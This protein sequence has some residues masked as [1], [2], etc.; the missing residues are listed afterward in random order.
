[1]SLAKTHE[2]YAHSWWTPDPWWHWVGRTFRLDEDL[3][4]H[5]RDYIFDPCPGDWDGGESG[6]EIPWEGPCYVNHP[7][8]RGGS[9]QLWWVKYQAEQERHNGMM[10]FVWCAFSVEQLRHLRPSPFH[11]C[12]WL[13]MPRTR[14]PFIWGGP[15]TPAGPN[16]SARVH[17]APMK[18][19]GNWAIWWSTE[20]PA[21][22]P[23]DCIVVRT[24]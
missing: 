1:M 8:D 7:G 20:E 21:I 17:G 4:D 11:L 5:P 24:C 19:P 12:G 10:P 13:V 18:S 3:V 2:N 9:A 23:V 6:L 14:T 22:P 16:R 15:D